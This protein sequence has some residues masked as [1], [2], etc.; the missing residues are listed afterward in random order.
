VA[1]LTRSLALLTSSFCCV[2]SWLIQVRCFN[3]RTTRHTDGTL[4]NNT[5]VCPG[6][7]VKKGKTIPVIGREG[8]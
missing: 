8:S 5:F 2:I 6:L 3:V 4:E 1:T 7:N